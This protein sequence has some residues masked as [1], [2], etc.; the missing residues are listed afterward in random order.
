MPKSVE[1]LIVRCQK[2]VTALEQLY[3]QMKQP[4]MALAFGILQEVSLAED[5]LQETFVRLPSAA[6]RFKQTASGKAF[7]LAIA[8]NVARELLRQH[9]NLDR[10][11]E[12]PEQAATAPDMAEAAQVR[13]M[14]RSL[15]ESQRELVVLHI[16]LGFSFA[17]IAAVQHLPA[18]TVR[19]RYAK[20][21]K[22][23]RK[24]WGN[25]DDEDSTDT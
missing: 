2:D 9:K 6:R 20:T 10:Q 5:C 1:E 24:E 17:E 15:S 3:R 23:L 7:V 22:I 16:Y 8:R 14:L 12:L 4:V 13:E 19:S 11:A 25:F 21:L 18:S